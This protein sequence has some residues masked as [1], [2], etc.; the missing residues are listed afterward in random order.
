M[1]QEKFREV[2][3]KLDRMRD[4]NTNVRIYIEDVFI[5]EIVYCTSMYGGKFIMKIDKGN[6]KY[7]DVTLSIDEGII[8]L[9]DSL[10]IGP[11][12]GLILASCEDYTEISEEY[13]VEYVEESNSMVIT[14]N[15]ESILRLNDDTSAIEFM[16][17]RRVLKQAIAFVKRSRRLKTDLGGLQSR[18]SSLIAIPNKIGDMSTCSEKGVECEEFGKYNNYTFTEGT[19]PKPIM[20][21]QNINRLGAQVDEG[22]QNFSKIYRRLDIVDCLFPKVTS[23]LRHN[24]SVSDNI[25]ISMMVVKNNKNLIDREILLK[26]TTGGR[27]VSILSKHK[28]MNVGKYKSNIEKYMGFPMDEDRFAPYDY[29]ESILLDNGLILREE[30]KDNTDILKEKLRQ[31]W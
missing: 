29:M 30:G 10:R 26:A 2:L 31:E 8:N 20:V 22:T 11:T 23:K 12:H 7:E 27:I 15:I 1:E 5:P 13:D 21:V 19:T 14:S 17:H 3:T 25:L 18:F 16:K 4:P 24:I 28:N 6:N 9:T